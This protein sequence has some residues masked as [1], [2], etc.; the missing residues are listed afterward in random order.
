MKKNYTNKKSFTGKTKNINT[1]SNYQYLFD[2]C[3]FYCKSMG[4]LND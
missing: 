3:F 1:K 2:G 4:G